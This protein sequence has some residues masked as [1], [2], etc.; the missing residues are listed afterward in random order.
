MTAL[1]IQPIFHPDW[2]VVEAH[3]RT[4]RSAD[5]IAVRVL[6]SSGDSFAGTVEAASLLAPS[7]ELGDEVYGAGTTLKHMAHKPQ[8]LTFL[9]AAQAV[10]PAITA[11]QM[12]YDHA[13]IRPEHRVLILGANTPTGAYA[14]QLA[15]ARGAEVFT[16]PGPRVDVVIDTLGRAAQARIIP[17]IK[18]CGSLISSIALLDPTIS[19]ERYIRSAL[20]TPRVTRALLHDIRNLFDGGVL[21]FQPSPAA[22][23]AANV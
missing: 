17:L 16:T 2:L 10:I 13:V 23:A 11:R 20:A 15:E 3:S 22:V 19:E 6:A 7:F 14:R 18:P 4:A 21:T 5:N 8:S 12:V 1:A 9:Q